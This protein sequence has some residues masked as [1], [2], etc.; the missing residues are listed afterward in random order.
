VYVAP[1]VIL[2][3]LENDRPESATCLHQDLPR[4][5]Q[6]FYGTFLNVES[7]FL[8]STELE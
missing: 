2:A 5:V 3:Y 4:T 8:E 6:T 7:R 1:F